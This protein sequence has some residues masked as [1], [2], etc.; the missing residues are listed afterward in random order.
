MKKA[1]RF[2]VQ[3]TVQGVFYRRFVLDHALSLGLK[4]FVR[5][6]GSGDV[7]VVVEGELDSI[8]RLASLLREG[9]SHSQIRNI[10]VEDRKW[11]GEFADFKVLRF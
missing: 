3:G 1:K 4:G 10:S 9:P 5:N 7:E 6:L 11:S 8:N 2:V